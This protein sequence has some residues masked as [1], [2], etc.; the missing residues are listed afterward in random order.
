[1]KTFKRILVSALAVLMVFT[2]LPVSVMAADNAQAATTNEGEWIAISNA[3]D[4][5]K[6][7]T[8]E[9]N[10]PKTGNYYLT[11]DL[12]FSVLSTETAEDGTR[13]PLKV[14]YLVQHFSGTL[15]GN[16]KT[17]SGFEINT[18]NKQG[19]V[20]ERLGYHGNAVIRNLKIGAP[21][22]GNAIV[23]TLNG[24]TSGAEFGFLAGIAPADLTSGSTDLI[25]RVVIENVH[26]YGE[27][28]VDRTGTLKLG[29]FVGYGRD[30]TVID[31]SFNGSIKVED[32][33][34]TNTDEKNIG[35]IIATSHYD[36]GKYRSTAIKNCTIN[37]KLEITTSTAGSE[38]IGGLVG[39]CGVSTLVDGCTVTGTLSGGDNMGGIAGVF[40]NGGLL[41]V[42]DCDTSG[43]SSSVCG[44]QDGGRMYV[45][46][47]GSQDT[48]ARDI[49]DF[50][51]GFDPNASY[52]WLIDNK[53]SEGE[54]ED[55]FAK[56][57]ATV[58][59]TDV[60]G[61]SQTYTYSTMG[62]YRLSDDVKMKDAEYTDA[63]VDQIF[64]GVL[65]GN[66][67]AIRNLTLN[68]NT[69][70]AGFFKGI[71]HCSG[72]ND[73][74][75]TDISFGSADSYIT[76]STNRQTSGVITGYAGHT[77]S[78][79][80]NVVF[81]GVNVYANVTH[82][83][84]AVNFGGLVGLARRVSFFDCNTYGSV[85]ATS[86]DALTSAVNVGGICATSEVDNN[87]FYNCNSYM[88]INIS[89][90]NA[91]SAKETRGGGIV[92]YT[93][94]N[95]TLIKCNSFGDISASKTSDTSTDIAGGFIADAAGSSKHVAVDCAVFGKLTAKDYAGGFAGYAAAPVALSKFYQFATMTGATTSDF[96]NPKTPDTYKFFNYASTVEDA[97]TMTTGASVRLSSDT[98]IRFK[99]IISDNALNRLE[100]IFGADSISYGV[101]ITP[102]AFYKAAGAATHEALDSYAKPANGFAEGEK[103]YVDIVAE[104]WFKGERGTIAGSIVKLPVER[105]NTGFTGVAYISVGDYTIYASNPQTRSI[106]YVAEK[107][108]DDTTTEK[109]AVIDG[110]T[111]SYELA[112]GET[113]FDNGEKVTVAEGQKI[114]SCYDETDRQTLRDII[115]P[116]AQGEN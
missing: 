46:G 23:A 87:V 59:Y 41:V 86:S 89:N 48:V 84:A 114:Y 13:L 34:N 77:T 88:D 6:I 16:G 5:R 12:D 111:Y 78:P 109:N 74:V 10:Y 65:D 103:A 3:A 52:V 9:T 20:F 50:G 32:D 85:N 67:N 108:L 2:M 92:A 66:G 47:C 113:Y 42:T 90:T 31:S 104:D 18:T 79:N 33:E 56:I 62:F 44:Y 101:L 54:F 98:G 11:D 83:G 107:A 63:V 116:P 29:G 115:D 112:V 106:K 95:L 91:S 76:M 24:S 93:A 55:E 73:T 35:G 22:E 80:Y 69:S 26:I 43:V 58:T 110:Y 36:S 99:G 81:N 68:D 49:G 39:Y 37:A 19:G 71:A 8:D 105:Y 30:M 51:N 97:I 25:D 53:N 21:G 1:M 40:G 14:S 4:F 7:G 15:E 17:L 70:D 102:W 100:G 61:A 28:T 38:R 75:I 57:G 82:T 64:G 94:K 72:G 27:C 60:N 45:R 96:V